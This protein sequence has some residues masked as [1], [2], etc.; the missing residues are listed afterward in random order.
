MADAA[1]AN[2]GM[3][4]FPIVPVQGALPLTSGGKVI[5]GIGVSGVHSQKDEQIAEAG[6]KLLE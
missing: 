6:A 5:G 4:N 3:L 2:V 1:A